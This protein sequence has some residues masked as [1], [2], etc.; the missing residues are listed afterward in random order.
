MSLWGEALSFKPPLTHLAL[1]RPLPCDLF[2]PGWET[3]W[4]C[5]QVNVLLPVMPVS[6]NQRNQCIQQCHFLG[7]ER[8]HDAILY[9]ECSLKGSPSWD[10][11]SQEGGRTVWKADTVPATALAG[12][13]S[14]KAALYDDQA[15]HLPGA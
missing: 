8:T 14:V 2:L 7:K 11:V 4:L 12:F 9:S 10:F 6:L 1:P 15:V 3:K 13:E 5:F